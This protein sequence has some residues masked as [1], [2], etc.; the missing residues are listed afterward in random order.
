MKSVLKKFVIK[1]GDKLCALVL[2]ISTV[3]CDYC[4]TL[5]Y[6]PKEPERL[7]EFIKING[8]SSML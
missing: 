5:L 1:Y 8:G 6:Q 3:A 2:V 7:K 4:R